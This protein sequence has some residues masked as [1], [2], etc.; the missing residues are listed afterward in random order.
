MES[1]VDCRPSSRGVACGRAWTRATLP[2]R[3]RQGGRSSD[4]SVLAAC[5]GQRDQRKAWL[6]V[7]VLRRGACGRTWT[8]VGS[9]RG[10]GAGAF[11]KTGP[12]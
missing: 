11:D 5:D 9:L 7:S 4:Q 6:T 12:L 3:E 10:G 1:L 8:D 2:S